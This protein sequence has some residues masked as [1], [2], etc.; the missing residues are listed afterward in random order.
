MNDS[1]LLLK[2]EIDDFK[3]DFEIMEPCFGE[4]PRITQINQEIRSIDDQLITLNDKVAILN[5]EIEN[6]T[7]HAD[8]LDYTIAVASGIVAGLIDSFFVGKWDFENA[9]A[10]S[11]KEINEKIMDIARKEGYTGDRLPGAIDKLEKN[12]MLLGDNAWKGLDKGISAKTHHLDDFSHHPTPV[13]LIFAIVAQFTNTG[14]YSNSEGKFIPIKLDDN[15]L[16]GTTPPAKIFCGIFN[17]CINVVKTTK[18]W[19][20]H[21]LSDMAGS[22]N[23]AGA[24]MGLPGPILSTLKEFSALP[25]VNETD[26]AKN[27]S[28]A[29]VH[30]IGAEK[31][32]QDL[33][34]FNNLFEGASSKV[35]LRT[36]NAIAH[37]L[38]RQALPV[39]INECLV[40]GFYFIR[41]LVSEIREKNR[42]DL[43]DWK[44]TLPFKNRTIVRMLTISSGTF[45]AIDLAD[46]TIRA[47]IEAKGFNPAT[48]GAFILRVNFV[49]I[50]RFVV[51]CTS[52]AYL[53]SNKARKENERFALGCQQLD[54]LNAKTFYK[55]A[56]LWI[57]AEATEQGIQAACDTMKNSL[58]AYMNDWQNIQ[59]DMK[60]IGT[61]V[62]AAEAKNQGLNAAIKDIL[63][64][65]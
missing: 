47:A 55:Q 9:K 15:G 45:M 6:Y 46:A 26:F 27:I 49:G 18:N 39:I 52:D 16:V 62:P 21:L 56:D 63:I 37:E 58:L 17:W 4:D 23:T 38:K 50:G 19:Q 35:D 60:I 40:R 43:I 24:G 51:A 48:A 42:I 31:N 7:N 41:K 13:G 64:W 8:G 12:F 29:F 1:G 30:G 10:I 65:G 22:K 33:G 44:S 54:L 61:V 57:S 34:I 3:I 11:N 36:E 53:G 14:H 25:L 28:K 5:G 2:S 59:D 20:G 32:Q